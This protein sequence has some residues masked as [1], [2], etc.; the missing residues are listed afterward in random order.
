MRTKQKKLRPSPEVIDWLAGCLLVAAPLSWLFLRAL[1][2][3]KGNL[4]GL[5]N[6]W[7]DWGFHFSLASSIAFRPLR[8]WLEHPAFADYPLHYPFLPDLL[9]GILLRFSGSYWIAFILPSVVFAILFAVAFYAFARQQLKFRAAALLLLIVWLGAGGM[10]LAYWLN[11]YFFRPEVFEKG[12][13]TLAYTRNDGR[14]LYLMNFIVGMLM[15]QRSLLIGATW[16]SALLV[17]LWTLR[18]RGWENASRANLIVAGIASGCL[19][20]IHPHSFLAFFFFCLFLFIDALPRWREGSIFGGA[21]VLVAVPLYL[22]FLRGAGTNG[23]WKWLPGW[24]SSEVPLNFFSLWWWNAGLFLPLAAWGTFRMRLWK[25]PYV[26]TGWALFAFAN[27]FRIQPW[28]WDNTKIFFWAYFAL[29]IPV[30]AYLNF[31]WQSRLRYSKVAVL[32]LV[33]LL[34]GASAVDLFRLASDTRSYDLM[35]TKD[36][37][38]LGELFRQKTSPRARVATASVPHHWAS[39]ISGRQILMGYPGWLWSHGVD[40]TQRDQEMRTLYQ[41]TVDTPGLLDELRVDYVVIGPH[42]RRQYRVNEDFFRSSYPL[43]LQFKDTRIY[44]IQDKPPAG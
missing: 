44:Q 28:L 8:T 7:A 32:F 29:A 15:P 11:D 37:I 13:P 25:N 30:A 22:L 6:I 26:L 33:P 43:L 41:G 31:L 23:F 4:L 17:R 20:L 10:G 36:E 38:E 14:Y 27:L 35:W 18:E 21:T 1:R 39:G 5:S 12:F 42:E 24:Y 3:D 34:V 2:F 16:M 40:S 19:L 9:S